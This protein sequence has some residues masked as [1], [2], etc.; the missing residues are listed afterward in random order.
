MRASLFPAVPEWLLCASGLWTFLHRF[1]PLS[2]YPRPKYLFILLLST[3][4][5]LLSH[6]DPVTRPKYLFRIANA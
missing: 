1:W 3:K 5:V 2:S 4:A 6:L